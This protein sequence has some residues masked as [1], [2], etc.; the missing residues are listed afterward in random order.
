MTRPFRLRAVVFDFDG[1]LTAPG[2]LDFPAIKR[3]LGCPLDRFVL[4]FVRELGEPERARA[5]AALERLELE[6]AARSRANEGAVDLVATLRAAGLGVAVVTRNGRAAVHRAFE[7]CA[8]LRLAD[9]GAVVT[10][11]DAV[12]PKPAPDGVLLACERLG[13]APNEALMVGDYALDVEAGR[14]AGA[15]TALLTNGAHGGTEVDDRAELVEAGLAAEH[16]AD[17]VVTRL[18]EL[19]AV[20]RLGLPLP[21]GKLPNDLLAGVLADLPPGGPSVL[22]GP[23]VGEDVAALDI[24]GEEVLV[25]HGDPITLSGEQLGRYAVTVNANDIATSG[26][27]PR[28]LLATV[29]LP[30]GT[31]ASQALALLEDLVAAAAADGIALAGGH[32]EVTSTVAQ[33]IVAATMLGVLRRADLRDR[34]RAAAGDRVVLTKALALEGTALLA[35]ELADE[36]RRLGL[37]DDE[38]AAGRAL[39]DRLSIVPEARVAAGLDGV[40]ALHD[41]TEGGLATALE[42]LALSCGLGVAVWPD[43]VPI[44]PETRRVCEALGLDPLGLIASGSLLV[45]CRAAEE[46]GLTAALRS[47]GVEVTTIGELTDEHEDVRV[48]VTGHPRASRNAAGIAWPRFA[49]DEA[50]RALEERGLRV[51]S[52]ASRD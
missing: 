36:L 52:A 38:L 39:L 15:L 20:V 37:T 42:E 41:V 47:S 45:T 7:N 51:R 40:T 30:R 9:F 8:G 35:A 21:Q 48:R 26:A 22:V 28:W 13:V 18:A 25:V 43:R 50:A 46:G 23:G 12:A 32:T 33:P 34:R 2:G 49:R 10:R 11:D 31:T 6:G 3:E 24:A 1:T 29:L 4:E 5:L 17:F 19:L 44:L 14:R 27:L 16:P